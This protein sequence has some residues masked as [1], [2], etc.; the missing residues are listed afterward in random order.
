MK[1]AICED[2]AF[3][4]DMLKGYVKDFLESKEMIFTIEWFDTAAKF[5][6]STETYD[7]LFLDYELPDSNGMEI[8]KNLRKTNNKTTIVFTT[9]FSEYVFDSFEV[10]TFRYLVKPV[11]REKIEKTMTDFINSFEQYAKIDIPTDGGEVVFA[12]LPEIMYIESNGRYTTVR[13]NSTSYVSSKALAT[14]QAE[15]NSFRFY[16][17]HRTFLVNMKYIAEIHGS[18]IILTNG[19]KVSI[20]RRNLSTFNNA[21]FNFLKYSDL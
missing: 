2:D 4:A 6:T 1:I 3:M 9:S 21:Y 11:S 7:L 12:T 13:L 8:A 16:R 19:E 18:T 15:I 14:F 5:Y 20:S 10:D 17:T